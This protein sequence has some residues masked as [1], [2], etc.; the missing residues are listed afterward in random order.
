MTFASRATSSDASIQGTTRSRPSAIEM[1]VLF[2]PGFDHTR[3]YEGTDTRAFGLLF[4]AALAMVWP[5]QALTGKI[6]PG[7]RNIL[8]GLGVVGLVGIIVLIMKLPE[9][10]R[11]AYI[12]SRGSGSDGWGMAGMV[13]GGL[14]WGVSAVSGFSGGGGMSGGGGATGS[15]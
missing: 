9:P 5:S 8:D 7:A 15:W 2:H 10:P 6:M 4:G 13:L 14:L 11:G 1:A 12:S 3:I